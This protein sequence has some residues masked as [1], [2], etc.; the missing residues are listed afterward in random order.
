MAYLKVY[1]HFIDELN[2][3]LPRNKR[4][5]EYTR[6][7]QAH[8]SLKDIIESE[9]VPHVEVDQI[10]VNDNF[11]G[12]RNKLKP[13]N[14]VTVLPHASTRRDPNE[15]H[16]QPKP[17]LKPRFMLD[18]HLGKL[19]RELR[20]CGID[21]LLFSGKSDREFSKQVI[22]L[23]RVTLTRDVELLKRAIIKRGYWIRND[24]PEKQLV[25]VIR[26]FELADSIKPF[27]RC[28][29]CNGVI[30][31]TNSKKI[32]DQV[33][34]RSRKWVNEYFQ[35]KSCGKIYWKGSHYRKMKEKITSVLNEL[36]E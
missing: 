33:P 7:I 34:P 14:R 26:R 10:K 23:K 9:G 19:A 5:R 35:C 24:D 31:K 21:S 4:Y 28:L 29:D 17:L 27:F 25:E 3:F 6:E 11:T 8:Q 13:G 20:M 36:T 15:K 1:I 16:L 12:F 32:K 18:E 2:D 22:R 30:I